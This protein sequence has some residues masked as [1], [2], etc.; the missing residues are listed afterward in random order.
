MEIEKKQRPLAV[1]AIGGNSLI[2]DNQHRTVLD[3]YYAAGNTANHIAALVLQGVDVVIT[4]G[5]G[6]QVGFIL[7]RSELAKKMLHEVPL[8]ICVAD[9]Q[10]AIGYQLAQTL[11]NALHER[12]CDRQIAALISQVVVS[13]D[14]PAFADASKPVGPYY[15]E[16]DAMRYQAEHGWLMKEDAG[17]GWRRVVPSPRPLEIV[18]L[19]TIRALLRQGC[20][21]I[22]GGGG[23]IPVTRTEDGLL[24]GC[25]AV[26]DKDLAS[27]L[28]ARQLD[29]DLF[30]ISTAVQKVAI[31][32]GKPNQKCLDHMTVAE[33]KQYMREGH[34]APGSMLPKIQAA[35]DYLEQGG[36]RVIITQPNLIS[37]AVN[38]LNG[39]SM[40][41]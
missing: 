7:L 18:E 26:V 29:A 12:R 40:T 25:A 27:S 22:A 38:N 14:D 9:T 31:N 36:K 10:G 5:N 23:G 3:Q 41:P 24:T 15:M 11:K 17:R 8:E 33:A 19:D 39:T 32:F 28:L 37:D 2:Q 35:L 34:F 21:V 13:A 6:P 30:I 4:H 20:I 1:I 16:T